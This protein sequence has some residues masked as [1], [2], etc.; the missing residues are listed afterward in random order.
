M[1]SCSTILASAMS[2]PTPL[3]VHFT[4]CAHRVRPPTM[5][6][7]REIEVFSPARVGLFTRILGRDDDFFHRSDSLFQTVD[8]GDTVRVAL[9]KDK[10]PVVCEP[11]DDD[12]A[13]SVTQALELYRAKLVER[14]GVRLLARGDTVQIPHFRARVAKSIPSEDS[15]LGGAA[16]NAAAALYAAN[17][18]CGRPIPQDELRAWAAEMGCDVASFMAGTGTTRCT[19]RATFLGADKVEPMTSLAGPRQGT[20]DL[21]FYVIV[22]ELS[23]STPQVFQALADDGYATLSR[24]DPQTLLIAFG[25]FEGAWLTPALAEMLPADGMLFI[26]DLEPP[27]LRCRPELRAIKEC[28]FERGGLTAVLSAQGTALHAVG[29]LADNGEDAGV[30]A[31]RL[32]RE[33]AEATGVCVRIFP[34][35]FAHPRATATGCWYAAPESPPA[36]LE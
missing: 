26:N 19:G 6:G 33:C 31:A 22:P 4:C 8:L 30:L 9:V 24:A 27:A 18:L 16:S 10:Q 11:A 5:Q 23:L 12:A 29:T 1:L 14:G 32:E 34:V 25:A 28:L 2:F 35:C 13:S 7:E 20:R 21:P 17:Q 3:S 15:G 36:E